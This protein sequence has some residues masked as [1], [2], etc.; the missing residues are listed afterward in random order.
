MENVLI[1]CTFMFLSCCSA[2]N[3]DI[4]LLVILLWFKFLGAKEMDGFDIGYKHKCY[5]SSIN[6]SLSKAYYL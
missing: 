4:C 5:R 6:R 3:D 1:L 2:G